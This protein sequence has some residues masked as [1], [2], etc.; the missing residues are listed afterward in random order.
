VCVRALTTDLTV[1]KHHTSRLG[2]LQ[3]NYMNEFEFSRLVEKYKKGLLSDSET[4]ALDKWLEEM[5]GDDKNELSREA[6]IRLKGKILNKIRN[7]T[8]DR[9]LPTIGHF[10]IYK[11]AACFLLAVFSFMTWLY[12]YNI[13]SEISIV[14]AVASE[15][16]KKVILPDKTIVWL[17]GNSAL[18]YPSHFS[19]VTRDVTL[20]GEAL[21][22]VTKD[23]KHP[24]I[25]HCG[26]LKTTVLGTSFNVKT[27]G[28]KIEVVVLTGKVSLSSPVDTKGTVVLS[29][30][31][32][33]Y[34]GAEKSPS[35]IQ[36]LVEPSKE[37]IRGTEYDMHFKDTGMENVIIRIEKKFNVTVSMK[38]ERLKNC[39]ITADF[40]DQSLEQTLSMISQ[41]LDLQYEV[42]DN[43]QVV[44]SGGG[45]D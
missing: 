16:I 14:E 9:P 26:D 27:L 20:K 32:I 1:G 6:K 18:N 31:R 42:S 8:Q 7:R 24:F 4:K 12:I 45:C 34:G 21:F 41:V 28:E 19:G 3:I 44:L 37:V 43:N 10:K 17:K 11:I 30:Q 22:E 38:N 15:G 39:M 33:V 29:N 40:T 2:Q 35:D 23:P 5:S 13:K 36:L 25:I